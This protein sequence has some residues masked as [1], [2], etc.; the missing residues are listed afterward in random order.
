MARI[1]ILGDSHGKWH[2]LNSVMKNVDF[3]LNI[4]YDFVIQVGD[5]GFFPQVFENLNIF[6]R[7]SIKNKNTIGST[8]EYS[9]L[10]FHKKVL[11]IDG[12]HENHE[13]LK[14]Q[15]YD[16]WKEKYN[17]HYQPRGSWIDLDGYKI[18]FMGGALHADR[19]QEGSID[20][21]TT[22][23]ILNKQVKK[24]ITEWNSVGG[25]DTVITHSCPTGLGIGMEGHPALYMAVQKY[26]VDAGYGAGNHL[27][28]GDEPLTMLYNGLIKKPTFQFYGH[29]HRVSNK[30]IGET[31]FICVGSTDSSDHKKYVN[32]FILDT[33][34]NSYEFHNKMALNF[35]GEH[36]T[37]V[38]D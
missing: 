18:G 9:P 4:K 36:S 12:N 17:I 2:D 5:F 37:W 7:K 21:E 8:S 14:K 23:Y 19:A 29:F 13:W 34:T 28:C 25:M 22:N 11:A 38:K 35:D 27:D 3:N 1:L 26:I 16:E 31:E 6:N 32:P 20:K 33:K 24:T 10:K 15:N 30:K